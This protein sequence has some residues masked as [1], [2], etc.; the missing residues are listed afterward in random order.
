MRILKS[1]LATLLIFGF[2]AGIALLPL[3]YGLEC[4]P[5]PMQLKKMEC[6]ICGGKRFNIWIYVED[7]AKVIWMVGCSNKH[8]GKLLDV[9]RVEG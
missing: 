7:S 1:I 5:A 3:A 2:V 4:V 6:P 8:C 9:G